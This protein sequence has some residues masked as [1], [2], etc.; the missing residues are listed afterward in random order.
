MKGT[1]IGRERA[2]LSKLADGT[3]VVRGQAVYDMP[4]A[5]FQYRATPDGAEFA[6]GLV[7]TRKGKTVLRSQRMAPP[8][9]SRRLPTR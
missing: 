1:V 6:D 2:L 4:Q 8:S 9:S 3:H 5:Q 7:V